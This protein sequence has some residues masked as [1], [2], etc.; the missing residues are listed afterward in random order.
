M[1]MTFCEYRAMIPFI[2]TAQP[3]GDPGVAILV[4]TK[5]SA[6]VLSE[7]CFSSEDIEMLTVKLA[8]HTFS[9]IYR[10]PHENFASF[11]C[12]FERELFFFTSE[13]VSS[14]IAGDFNADMSAIC[15]AQ[16]QL[17]LFIQSTRFQN[18]IDSPT[19]ITATCSSV[20]DLIVTNREKALC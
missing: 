2:S 6:D 11:F 8:R 13:S 17:S 14:C 3:N 9:V 7:H 16:Q 12:T 15:P 19:R 1:I 18:V 4:K 20:L 10:P 5:Y